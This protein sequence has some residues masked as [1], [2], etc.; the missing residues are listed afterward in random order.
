VNSFTYF[1]DAFNIYGDESTKIY[2]T[3]EFLV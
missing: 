1:S 2:L 3:Q